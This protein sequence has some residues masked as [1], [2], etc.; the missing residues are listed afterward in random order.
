MKSALEPVS[1]EAWEILKSR[2]FERILEASDSGAFVN[3][4]FRDRNFT[5]LPS[6]PVY[7]T[8]IAWNKRKSPTTYPWAQ[9]A[10]PP[11]M[12]RHRGIDLSESSFVG[13]FLTNFWFRSA[14]LEGTSFAG[15]YI[16]STSFEEANLK[17]ACFVGAVLD[18]VNFSAAH[19]SEAD[20]SLAIIKSIKL[21]P[22]TNLQRAL[23]IGSCIHHIQ[24][25]LQGL[26]FDQRKEIH[27][28]IQFFDDL[29]LNRKELRATLGLSASLFDIDTVK[30]LSS[31]DRLTRLF[32][33]LSALDLSAIDQLNPT[34]YWENCPFPAAS[35][36]A[37]KLN[38]SSSAPPHKK[39][40]RQPPC[41]ST[42]RS[43]NQHSSRRFG[44]E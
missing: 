29:E 18:Q 1:D 4:D 17:G 13:C 14:I 6:Y 3:K 35:L 30:N 31:Q 33:L 2:N 44:D 36:K 12:Q 16:A 32:T 40:V 11:S 43:I 20:F 34:M 19:A 42:S 28:L 39:A 21:S 5:E 23:W 26:N 27:N 10:V 15:A 7:H 22:R 8:D 9:F 38:L 24:P 25:T 37:K 41:T